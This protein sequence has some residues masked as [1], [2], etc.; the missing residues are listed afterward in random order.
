MSFKFKHSRRA[1]KASPT[2]VG[3]RG[4]LTQDETQTL[5]TVFSVWA[6]QSPALVLHM[7]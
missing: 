7:V 6:L 4:L 3:R 1:Q 5:Q 2:T